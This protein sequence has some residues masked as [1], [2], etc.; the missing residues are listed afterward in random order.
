MGNPQRRIVLILLKLADLAVVAAAFVVAIGLALRH[1][2]DWLAVL[3][4]RIK[5]RNVAFILAYLGYWHLVFTG[6]GLYRSHR[7]ST[8]SREWRHLTAAV[9]VGA[10]PIIVLRHAMHFSFTTTTFLTWFMT[11]VFL[12]L[13][14]ERRI[15]R[16]VARSM[17][18]HGRNLRNVI[19]IGS[20]PAAFDMSARLARRADLGYRVTALIDAEAPGNGGTP[21]TI[22]TSGGNGHHPSNA[23]SAVTLSRIAAAI[24]EN[25]I[26]EVFIALPLDSAQPLIR[27]IVALCEEQG[28]TIRLLSMVVEPLLAHAQLDELDDRPVITIF[29]GPPDSAKLLVKRAFDVLASLVVLILLSPLLLIAAIAIKLDSGGPVLFVQERV[30][31][32]RRRFRAYKFRTMVMDAE[33][34]QAALEARNEAIGPVFKIRNDPRITRL[35]T[36]LRHLSLDELPQLL[37]VLRGD[38]SLVGPRPL[39]LRDVSLIDTAAHKRRFSVKPG[40]TCLWQINGRKPLFDDWVRADMEYIDRWSLSLDFKILLKTIPAVL[41][42]RGA[43]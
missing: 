42:R 40:I 39:P 16:A 19:L 11:L 15:L 1:S 2:G 30:G 38:M 32:N 7:L 34:Q 13:A 43:Y 41:S 5:V 12:G 18:R 22:R 27:S 23:P 28:I 4:L 37:N 21:E 33:Q 20:G 17:R 29:T 9:C 8:I 25:P 24:D 26:D 14:I 6:L 36:W 35:G 10:A 3:E 31:L